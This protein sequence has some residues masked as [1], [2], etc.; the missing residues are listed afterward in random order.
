[1]AATT[2]RGQ[3]VASA[4]AMFIPAS[5]PGCTS[6]SK[7]RFRPAATSLPAPSKMTAPMG[8]L[9][10]TCACQASAKDRRHGAL[11]PSHASSFGTPERPGCGCLRSC[12]CTDRGPVRLLLM[13]DYLADP[14]WY[15]APTGAGTWPRSWHHADEPLPL[16]QAPGRA[17]HWE[18]Q[19]DG[20]GRPAFLSWAKRVRRWVCSDVEPPP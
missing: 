9:P 4:W 18:Q 15:R 20:S 16:L 6:L 10:A 5:C 8:T 17:G 11:S 3:G 19:V 1:M 12:G 2:H 13:A 14:L 7:T